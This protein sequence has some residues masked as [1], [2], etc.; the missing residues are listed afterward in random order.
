MYLL[1]MKNKLAVAL[2]YILAVA[3]HTYS[4]SFQVHCHSPRI[5]CRPGNTGKKSPPKI[6]AKDKLIY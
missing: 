4:E 3:I 1:G 5:N 6:L 2:W